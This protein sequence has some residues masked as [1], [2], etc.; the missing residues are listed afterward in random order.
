MA[1]SS[2]GEAINEATEK[3]LDEAKKGLVRKYVLICKSSTPV[4]LIAFKKG[5]F[6]TVEKEAKRIAMG[7][8]YFGTVE[9]SG[10]VLTF[11]LARS[12]GFDKAPTKSTNMVEFFKEHGI[13]VSRV[14]FEIV[15]TVDLVLDEND[16]LVIRF[17]KLQP[18]A[19]VASDAHPNE[20][21]QIAALCRQVGSH[22]DRD[23][24]KQALAKLE[25]LEQKL[26]SL[27][28][29]ATPTAPAANVPPPP[30]PPPPPN[31]PTAAPKPQAVVDPR[32]AALLD[33]LKSLAARAKDA[34]GKPS[35]EAA[36]LKASEAGAAA[37][38][39]KLDL[40]EQLARDAEALLIKAATET[41]VEDEE[42]DE[43]LAPLKPFSLV[44]AQ[45]ARLIWEK[46]CKEIRSEVQTLEQTIR[47]AIA[48]HNE[49][50]T[51]V[52]E[53]GAD[54]LE[55]A[56]KQL[57]RILDTLDMR[58]ADKLDAALNAE[59]DRR[60]A[61]HREAVTLI[62]EYRE[63]AQNDPLMKNV[64]AN[65]FLTCSIRKRVDKTLASLAKSI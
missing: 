43:D 22:I 52:D 23:E 49:D 26:I 61:L 33:I 47:D 21:G 64:D 2:R 24:D 57:F 37:R 62:E 4:S 8:A 38:G 46:T 20:A 6:E 44:N 27:R 60:A 50:P 3:C 59:G 17:R 58:L 63:F 48:A 28:R 35:G 53:Y 1:E 14:V 19:V 56:S 30:V 42:A 34:A 41:I 65:P 12:D 25:E 55:I 29:P 32:L 51:A 9:G 45:A 11:K 36:R 5:K 15:E 7:Q 10:Q 13:E 18:E 31:A 39:G 16:P 40:A 54:E